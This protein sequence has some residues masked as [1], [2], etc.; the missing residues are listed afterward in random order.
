MASSLSPTQI[1]GKHGAI[2][3]AY[4]SYVDPNRHGTI[5]AMEAA[6]FLKKS[7]LSDVVLSRIWDLS[8]PGGRGCLDKTGMFIALKLIALAQA[9]RDINMS[10]I[11]LDMP[12]PNMG[13]VA[14]TLPKKLTTLT[15]T[16]FIGS[17]PSS[18]VDWTVNSLEREKYNN[19]FDSLQPVNGVIPGNKVKGVLMESKLPVETLGQIWELA[20][21]DKDGSLNRDEFIAAMHL[22]YKALEKHAIPSELPTELIAR[23]EKNIHT[24]TV[25]KSNVDDGRA[26]MIH[27]PFAP[28]VPALPQ[29]KPSL[30]AQLPLI[31]NIL[32]EPIG[33]GIFENADTNASLLSGMGNSTPTTL[34]SPAGREGIVTFE[35]AKNSLDWVV[36]VDERV[37][38]DMLFVKSDIDRDGFVSGMEIKDVFLQSGV[39]QNV[40]AHIWALCDIRQSG[41]LNSEQFAL[42]MWFVAKRLKG[43][44]PPASL[45]QNMMPPSFRTV[46]KPRA[47]ENN[48]SCYSNPELEMINKD[49]EELTRE[50]LSL[51]IDISQKEG[52]ILVKGGELKSLQS[53]LDSLVATW[54][55]LDNQKGEA[56]KR[57]GDLK[58]QVDKLRNQASDQADV[59]S[60]E[61]AEL[62]SRK[63]QLE[64]LKEEELR[65]DQLKRG[66][67]EK[68][69]G[70]SSKLQDTQL[71]ISQAKALISQ[72]EEQTEQMSNALTVCDSAI[73]CRNVSNIADPIL[74]LNPDFRDSQF[75]RLSIVNGRVEENGFY[76]KESS[77]YTIITTTSDPF[78]NDNGLTYTAGDHFKSAFPNTNNQFIHDPFSTF[79]SK[80]Q[81]NTDPFIAFDDGNNTSIAPDPDKDV[82][83]CDPFAVLH[84]PIRD[85]ALDRSTSPSPALPPK[86]AKPPRPAPPRPQLPSF[87][88]AGMSTANDQIGGGC[89]ANSGFANF[90]NFENDFSST[91][92][93]KSSPTI[94]TVVRESASSKLEFTD[95]PFRDYRYEDPFNIAFEEEA[96]FECNRSTTCYNV[97]VSSFPTH[98]INVNNLLPISTVTGRLSAPLQNVY[99]HS[100]I[101]TGICSNNGRSSVPPKFDDERS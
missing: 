97:A 20:D 68:L 81:P 14:V 78:S 99:K 17:L 85:E 57:L 72:L 100:D 24:K 52:G 27:H 9:G 2:Y 77:S 28:P 19:T 35:S 60:T 51:E 5:G 37:K 50:K 55:Q 41:K 26:N 62:L 49:V 66:N 6:R 40:L 69:N 71:N 30:S 65:L 53:E 74:S 61:E 13:E 10:N 11:S 1:T 63:E 8:D 7:G 87:N 22:V 48:N 3:E 94:T 93:R 25:Q 98:D 88:K 96:K 79:N 31:P 80:K 73:E 84:A 45:A 54:K 12:P 4:Y 59:I 15:S 92:P 47:I 39:P 36:S 95:D 89:I 82:F 90:A 21:Q 34:I 101:S 91:T 67:D 18:G 86:K 58:N 29:V 76:G 38:S 56:Y 44:D 64:S 42:A 83:G 46:D 16:P 33:A 75:F 43:Q 70:L 32:H 23:V